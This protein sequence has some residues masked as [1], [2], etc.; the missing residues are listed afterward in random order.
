[1]DFLLFSLVKA[2][3]KRRQKPTRASF[4]MPKCPHKFSR[5]EREERKRKKRETDRQREERKR[6]ET[7]T[8]ERGGTSCEADRGKCPFFFLKVR[9]SAFEK[10]SF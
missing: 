3:E 10:K 9:E 6:R 8:R 4:F 5:A 7:E 1:M 2:R